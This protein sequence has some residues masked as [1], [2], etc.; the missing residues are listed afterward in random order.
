MDIRKDTHIPTKKKETE[1]KSEW[2]FFRKK[3]GKK[4]GT[5]D[6]LVD[7]CTTTNRLGTLFSENLF[8]ELLSK[9]ADDS[10]MQGIRVFLPWSRFGPVLVGK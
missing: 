9:R 10:G 7:G 8:K 5:D 4:R 3:E 6:G 2:D 1:R